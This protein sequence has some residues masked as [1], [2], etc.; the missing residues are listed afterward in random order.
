MTPNKQFRVSDTYLAHFRHHHGFLHLDNTEISKLLIWQLYY[1]HFA[2]IHSIYYV[3]DEIRY[4][5][6]LTKTTKTKRESE[7]KGK[8]LRGLWHKHF[9]SDRF[10]Y[11]NIINYWEMEKKGNSKLGEMIAEVFQSSE[12]EYMTKEMI[13]MLSYRL[14]DEPLKNK[15]LKGLSTGE[16][17]VFAKNNNRNY[18]L[19]LGRHGDDEKIYELIRRCCLTEYPFLKGIIENK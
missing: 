1:A 4:L 13:T 6:G 3:L 9:Y 5:E 18:Y 14:T 11:R 12:S 15:I 16:W 8:Y 2:R 19:V 7:F 17:L 10:I